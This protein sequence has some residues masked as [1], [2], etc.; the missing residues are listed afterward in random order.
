MATNTCQNLQFNKDICANFKDI[1]L[2]IVCPM[3]HLTITCPLFRL[4]TSLWMLIGYLQL[5][6]ISWSHSSIFH[7][8]SGYMA[9]YTFVK[10]SRLLT[11]CFIWLV[12]IKKLLWELENLLHWNFSAKFSIF[13]EQLRWGTNVSSLGTSLSSVKFSLVNFWSYNL[14]KL[15]LMKYVCSK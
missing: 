5:I 4:I 8:G 14:T 3:S 13:S 9:P 12:F 11:R 7:L 6:S 1:H 2:T 15:N 10:L